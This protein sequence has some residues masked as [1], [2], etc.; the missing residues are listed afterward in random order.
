M[1][2]KGGSSPVSEEIPH[3][4]SSPEEDYETG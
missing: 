4:N 1:L 2:Q 3:A